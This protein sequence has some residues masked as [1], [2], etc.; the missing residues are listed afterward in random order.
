MSAAGQPRVSVLLPVRNGGAWFA[1][2]LQSI[3]DQQ[4]CDFE[5]IVVDDGSS[6]GT[7]ELLAACPDPRLRVL[8]REGGG[9][10]AALNA[11]LELAR[12]D[13]VA[14]MDADDIALPGRL[15]RQTTVLDGDAG[16]VL[17]HGSVDVID[18]EGRRIG[19]VL[20]QPC[21]PEARRAE[22]MWEQDLYPIIHPA[23]MIRRGTLVAM[24]GYRHSPSAEDHELWLRLM[25]Q[26]RLVAQSDKVLLYRQHDG[27]ISRQRAV[28][29]AVSGLVNCTCAR[30]FDATGSDLYADDPDLYAALRTEAERIGAGAFGQVAAARAVRVA[31]RSG[32]FAAAL[33]GAGRLLAQGKLQLVSKAAI[34]RL[35][36]RLQ[37]RLLAWL[38]D[39]P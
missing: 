21:T 16:A 12:G 19:E 36:V 31:A 20:A 13:Y 14:R 29:Q 30:W 8:R 33:R 15:A 10:V 34:R 5:L 3:L 32:H 35:H 4:G 22:L 28:E 7:S 18:A 38:Q 25:R 17:V 23:V 11:G 39:R 6:D 2:A 26:G 9:L 1:L 27:G 37:L 24:G